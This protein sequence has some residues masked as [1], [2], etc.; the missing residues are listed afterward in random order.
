[1]KTAVPHWN[2][3]S[4]QPLQTCIVQLIRY[5]KALNDICRLII[6]KRKTNEV[7]AEVWYEIV[8]LEWKHFTCEQRRNSGDSDGDEELH[9]Q[10]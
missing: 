2:K 10:N 8:L 7:Q 5:S 4:M 3:I 6:Q 1:M 9:D